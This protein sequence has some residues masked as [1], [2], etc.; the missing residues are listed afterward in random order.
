MYR[1]CGS[2]NG[3][4]KQ[5]HYNLAARIKQPKQSIRKRGTEP[6]VKS[7]T[8]P[9]LLRSPHSYYRLFTLLRKTTIKRLY[10][11]YLKLMFYYFVLRSV[12]VYY[13]FTGDYFVDIRRKFVPLIYCKNAKQWIKRTKIRLRAIAWRPGRCALARTDRFRHSEII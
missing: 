7:F 2:I 13:Y 5:N 6:V 11:E 8:K 12:I 10:I 1:H 9:I 3:F 4:L